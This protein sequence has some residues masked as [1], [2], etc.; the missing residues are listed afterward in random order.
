[1]KKIIRL[2]ILVLSVSPFLVVFFIYNFVFNRTS[3]KGVTFFSVA[4]A[5]VYSGGSGGSGGQGATGGG[6]A[7]GG[8]GGAASGGGS[9]GG[10]NAA[11]QGNDN[12]GGNNADSSG[13]VS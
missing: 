9:D 6:D 7:N 2:F 8:G 10:G 3:D 5:D 12:G 4:E 1:M 13:G 11:A